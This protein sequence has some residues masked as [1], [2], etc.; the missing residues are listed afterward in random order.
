MKLAD[1][2]VLAHKGFFN[3]ESEN[4][5]REN[6]KEVCEISSKKNYISIIELD[7]RKSKDGVLYCYHGNSFEYYIGLEIPK[8]FGILQEKY[9]VNSLAEVLDVISE[10]KSIFLDIKDTR[11][12]REDIL[13]AF[14]KKKFKE[15]ILGNKSISFLNRFNEMP[16][17]FVKIFNGN[18]LCNF[19]DLK[20][21]RENNF[22]Y[23]EVVFPFQVR[24]KLIENVY[25]AGM[26]F[27]CTG[28][29][30]MSNTSYWK[31]IYK[32]GIKHVSSDF[33]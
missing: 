25:R 27:R 3:K 9:K 31:K 5:Y 22:R 10:E 14:P 26:E 11:I 17:E 18:I 32:Y 23:F 1:K 19:Y 20:K 21:L 15:V 13:K 4:F 7:I 6:S 33:I 24:K 2:I 28:L 30:F 8:N 16:R 12:T 29:F